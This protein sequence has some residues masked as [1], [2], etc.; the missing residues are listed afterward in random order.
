MANWTPDSMVGGLFRTVAKRVPPPQGVQPAV[1]W[2]TENRIAELLGP[3]CRDLRTTRRTCAWRFPSA[4]ACLA[5]FQAWYGPV[6]AAFTA[7]GD[8]GRPAFESDLL[9]V[10]DGA[11]TTDDGTL[12]MEVSYLEVVGVRA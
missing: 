8:E 11:N 4:A 6:V 10:F 3:G 5:Y 9:A 12:A 1:A 7:V 2:G